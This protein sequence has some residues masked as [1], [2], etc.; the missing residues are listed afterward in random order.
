MGIEVDT[1][2][3]G[4]DLRHNVDEVKKHVG[5][6]YDK[7]NQILRTIFLKDY[8]NIKFKILNL[9]LREFYAFIINNSERLKSDFIIFSGQRQDQIMY[10]ENRL[11]SL[12]FLLKKHTD[13]CHSRGM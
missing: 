1:H 3:H 2:L 5:L 6:S 4:I 10:L 12:E 8:G 7:T 11:E 9:K 13:I